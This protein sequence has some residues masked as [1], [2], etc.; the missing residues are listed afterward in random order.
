MKH[1]NLQG[2]L[3]SSGSKQPKGF[4]KFLKLTKFARSLPPQAHINGRDFCCTEK[5]QTSQ[6]AWKKQ[7]PAELPTRGSDHP[8]Y[9]KQTT[10]NASSCL[11]VVCVFQASGF[12]ELSLMLRWPFGEIEMFIISVSVITLYPHS[13]N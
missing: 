11:K 9:L 8:N 7:R 1:F 2:G 10:S 6:A 3:L 4:R 13:Y 12:D 5:D